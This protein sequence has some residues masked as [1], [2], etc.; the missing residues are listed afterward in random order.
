MAARLVAPLGSGPVQMDR[1]F[2]RLTL[3]VATAELALP[4]LV[5]ALDSTGVGLTGLSLRQPSLDDAFIA[6]TGKAVTVPGREMQEVQ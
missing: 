3:P 5:R 1:D 6:L 2:H 4:S